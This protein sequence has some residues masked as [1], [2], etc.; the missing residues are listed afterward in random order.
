[1]SE[2]TSSVRYSELSL[3]LVLGLI[4]PNHGYLRRRDRLSGGCT[5]NG[6]LEC[7]V[8]D[9]RYGVDEQQIE[10]HVPASDH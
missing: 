5:S 10:H 6:N 7:D 2:D 8:V 9:D 1:M 4:L 3:C